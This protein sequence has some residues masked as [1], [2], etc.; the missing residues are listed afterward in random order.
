MTT[1]AVEAPLTAKQTQLQRVL[2]AALNDLNV[3]AALAAIFS[4]IGHNYSVFLN[5]KGGAGTMTAAGALIA[6]HPLVFVLA[7]VIPLTMTYI[8]LMPS[9][10]SL[11]GS[12]IGLLL[13]IVLVGANQIPAASLL[14]FGPFFLLSWYSHRPNSARLRAGNERRIGEKAKAP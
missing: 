3:D 6:L 12:A 7:A 14:F 10:G 13:G 5:F 9:I 4:V 2:T 11:L 1:S 8:T